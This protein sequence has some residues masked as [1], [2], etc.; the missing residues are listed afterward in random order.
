M[1]TAL[2]SEYLSHGVRPGGLVVPVG[3][4]CLS[5]VIRECGED[6]RTR[7]KD[8]RCSNGAEKVDNAGGCFAGAAGQ[9][10]LQKSPF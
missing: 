7:G 2:I 8:T 5:P 6:T 4:A 3:F 10:R 1:Y 9:L